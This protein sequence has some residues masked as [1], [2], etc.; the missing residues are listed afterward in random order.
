MKLT[1]D[2]TAG[3]RRILA[4]LEEIARPSASDLLYQEL[5]RA[6]G[7]GLFEA[8]QR[9]VARDWIA[10]HLRPAKRPHRL[11]VYA[12]KHAFEW[13]GREIGRYIRAGDFAK[14][15]TAAGIRVNGDRVYATEIR[16]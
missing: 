3:W 11:G 8:T 4:L 9:V 15:L 14:L 1:P 6:L 13:D 2:Q 12:L 10:G 7:N 5:C 16:S